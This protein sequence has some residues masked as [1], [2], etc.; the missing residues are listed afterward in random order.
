MCHSSKGYYQMNYR[1]T[2]F[3]C[4]ISYIVQAIAVN[5]APLFFVIFKENYGL[6][7]SALG[8]LILFTFIV[9]LVV[10]IASMKFVDAFGYKNC[11]LG[12]NI[13]AFI[14]IVLLSILP[15][16][17]PAM[18]ALF[19]SVF[20]YSIGGGLIEVMVNPIIEA[21][22]SESVGA[23]FSLLHSFYSWG[24]TAVILITTLLLFVVGDD[25]WNYLPLIWAII[26]LVNIFLF[27][28]APIPE[29]KDEGQSSSR[30]KDL[31]KTPILYAFLILMICGGSTEMVI[32]QWASYF[33]EKGLGVAKVVGD[34][35][36]PCI[37]ALMMAL[38]RTAYGIFGKK[39]PIFK[40]LVFCSFLGVISYVGITFI[41]SPLIVMACFALV[42]IASSLLWPGTLT[43]SNETLPSGGT[44][45]YALLAFAGDIGCS[46]GPWLNGIVNDGVMAKDGAPLLS[47][48]GMSL[49]QT[50]LRTAILVCGIFPLIML[51]TLFALLPKLRKNNK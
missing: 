14:G 7:A 9:Q 19:I 41:P 50:S 40:G 1:L 44:A 45:M 36:G 10:D 22:P 37:F 43:L 38:G 49:E 51:V 47:F 39:I 17:M 34:L 31:V 8:F 48:L 18:P 2:K 42:G 12:A 20:F 24:Q 4:Y 27:A 33:A 21:I 3:S 26:P 35:L 11:T 16:V 28:K 6:S 30:V 15:N 46:V 29:I 5:L 23:S 32:S 25:K 13:S